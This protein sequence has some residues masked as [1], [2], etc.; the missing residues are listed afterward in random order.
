MVVPQQQHKHPYR[1]RV[2]ASFLVLTLLGA[3]ALAFGVGRFVATSVAPHDDPPRHLAPTIMATTKHRPSSQPFHPVASHIPAEQAGDEENPDALD[4][5]DDDDEDTMYVH[6]LMDLLVEVDDDDRISL[7]FQQS[8]SSSHRLWD[9]FWGFLQA[10]LQW[11]PPLSHHCHRQEAE[12]V[13]S[14]SSSTVCVALLRDHGHVSLRS[15]PAE[16]IGTYD[17]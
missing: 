13:E 6:F 7:W 9:D 12:P 14:S 11:E 8:S 17:M 15:W 3:A 1:I 16:H 4:D 10:E 2:S 5:D